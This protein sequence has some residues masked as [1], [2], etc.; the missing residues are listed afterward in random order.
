M[1]LTLPSQVGVLGRGTQQDLVLPGLLKSLCAFL[2]KKG[3]D[4]VQVLS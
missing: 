2:D 1:G 3:I 4:V